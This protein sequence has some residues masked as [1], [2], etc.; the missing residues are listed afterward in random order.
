MAGDNLIQD[1]KNT[2]VQKSKRDIELRKN[3]NERIEEYYK[4]AK[5]IL[6][7]VQKTWDK[8]LYWRFRK[9]Y[10]ELYNTIKRSIETE[11]KISI[12]ERNQIKKEYTDIINLQSQKSLEI[13]TKKIFH[14]GKSTLDE[15]W[16]WIQET[17]EQVK[18]WVHS[19]TSKLML[20]ALERAEKKWIKDILDL[21]KI[22]PDIFWWLDSITDKKKLQITQEIQKKEKKVYRKRAIA[23]FQEKLIDKILWAWTFKKGFGEWYIIWYNNEKWW[24]Y[25]QIVNSFEEYLKKPT[26]KVKWN[27][28]DNSVINSKALAGYL[29]YLKN[30]NGWNIT[31]EILI[32]KLGEKIARELI[33]HWKQN[34]ETITQSI[35]EESW[36]EDIKEGIISLEDFL[37]LDKNWMEEELK[38]DED[39]KKEQ[40]IRQELAN[41]TSLRR[42]FIEKWNTWHCIIDADNNFNKLLKYAEK[43]DLLELKSNIKSILTNLYEKKAKIPK[44]EA[45]KYANEAFNILIENTK[46]CISSYILALDDFHKTKPELKNI[47]LDSIQHKTYTEIIAMLTSY[48]KVVI[49]QAERG[50]IWEFVKVLSDEELQN[51]DTL[52][53][54]EVKDLL[55][56]KWFNEEIIDDYINVKKLRKQNQKVEKNLE[57]F[58][59]FNEEEYQNYLNELEKWTDWETAMKKAIQAYEIRIEKELEKK[60]FYRSWE[61][62]YFFDENGKKVNISPEEY[63]TISQSKEAQENLV[64]F[65]NTLSELRLTQIWSYRSDIFTAIG[66]K[67]WG[68]EFKTQDNDYLNNNEVAFFLKYIAYSVKDSK[69]FEKNNQKKSLCKNIID[70]E[71][72]LKKIE[73]DIKTINNA[74]TLKTWESEAGKSILEQAFYDKFLTVDWKAWSAESNVNNLVAKFTK[75]IS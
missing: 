30:Q 26:T 40:S 19:M 62:P 1:I 54:E 49:T 66:N 38:K 69:T 58:K 29:M 32:D 23:K 25:I 63:N 65:Y 17:F 6:E 39:W 3:W 61:T 73:N 64:H 20:W 36:N 28:N 35:L 56:S 5:K 27:I 15:A 11:K 12:E 41:N 52:S 21:Y 33:N 45:N 10:S 16:K 24:N 50:I 55:I 43:K 72:D 7:D 37:K 44:K 71:N 4:Q 8:E 31:Q 9:E 42:K 22:N 67:L 13:W 60:W 53:D 2:E 14:K 46:P 18:E 48:K 57:K 34:G 75:A 70:H 51:L 74:W 59:N 47:K 68:M